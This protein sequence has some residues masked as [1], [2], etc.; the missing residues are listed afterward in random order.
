MIFSINPALTINIIPAG[1]S[2]PKKFN[3]G[4]AGPGLGGALYNI[5]HF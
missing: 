2:R 1:N 5:P 3:P 4:P